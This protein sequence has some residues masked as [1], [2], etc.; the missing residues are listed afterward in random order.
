MVLVDMNTGR[1]AEG[2]Q[3]GSLGLLSKEH[4][5]IYFKNRSCRSQGEELRNEVKERDD[6]SVIR[7][8]RFHSLDPL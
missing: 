8:E 1:V 7:H 2:H 4:S 5:N 6:R 3:R